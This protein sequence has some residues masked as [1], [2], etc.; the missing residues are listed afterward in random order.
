MMTSN[1]IVSDMLTELRLHDDTLDFWNPKIKYLLNANG[2]WT[3]LLDKLFFKRKIV[4]PNLE[5]MQKKSKNI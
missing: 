3:L 5:V 2:I 1:L 4:R